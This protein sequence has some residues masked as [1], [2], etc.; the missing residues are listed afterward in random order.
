MLDTELYWD[1]YISRCHRIA[2]NAPISTLNQQLGS[3]ENTNEADRGHV[4]HF[5]ADAL[6]DLPVQ[7]GQR[8]VD[9]DG[10]CGAA[11]FDQLADIT[12]QAG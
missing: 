8:A 4:M 6:A 3:E 11:G 9:G 10:Q 7:Q 1:D 5:V 2:T 12:Q